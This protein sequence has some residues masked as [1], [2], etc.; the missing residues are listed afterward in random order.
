MKSCLVFVFLWPAHDHS[1]VPSILAETNHWM[2]LYKPPHWL[3]NVDSKEA[4][5]VAAARP[6]DEED[7]GEDTLGAMNRSPN[8]LSI[9]S[10]KG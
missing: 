7:D 1:E 10:F 6:F 3:V 4:A 2:A 9:M 8:R 5:K